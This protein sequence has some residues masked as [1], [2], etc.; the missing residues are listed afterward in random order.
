MSETVRYVFGLIGGVTASLVIWF[1]FM[2]AIQ[3]Q[4]YSAMNYALADQWN[5]A[6][7]NDGERQ[8]R[9]LND[10]WNETK[11]LDVDYYVEEG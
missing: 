5:T 7:G 1:F 8:S 2:S 9:I 11:E 4:M 3:P 10:V 6:T